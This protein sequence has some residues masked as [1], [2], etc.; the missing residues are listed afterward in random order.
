MSCNICLELGDL[1]R[2][3]S[4]VIEMHEECMRLWHS[5]IGYG[6][7]IQSGNLCCP[8]CKSPGKAQ[9]MSIFEDD[10]EITD[11]LKILN[12]NPDWTHILC[13]S[14][15]ILKKYMQESCVTHIDDT[16]RLVCSD[17]S[18]KT[19]KECPTCGILIEKAEG[20]LHMT[21]NCGT[22]FC[23]Q[24]LEIH[25]KDNIYKHINQKHKNILEDQL[26]YEDY[27][28][29]VRHTNLRL[30]EVPEEYWT[31]ELLLHA[32][33]KNGMTLQFINNQ[34][35]EI[36]LEA[37][38][39]TSRAFKYV[40]NK[41]KIICLEAVKKNGLLLDFVENQDK[42]I[43]LEAVRK[44]G[45]TLQFINNQTEE[46][47]LEAVKET[48]R[49]FKYVKHKTKIICLEA[50]KKNGL[51]LDFVENQDEEI[52]L[53]AIRKNP[54]ALIY[55]KD[56]TKK[57]CLE[58]VRKNGNTLK[59]VEKQDEEI[60]LEAVKETSYAFQYV[61]KEFKDQIKKLLK[62]HE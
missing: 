33:R 60:C 31:K 56:K 57:I 48:S 17:C 20:C 6:K 45:M 40:K 41:T 55:V 32:V 15:K 5:N 11:I 14:C 49:A 39:E 50:V 54:F 12:D 58:A 18:P 27:I 53:D 51:L 35:E 2:P 62:I 9:Y 38:K 47:C 19:Y 7:V 26:R 59:C 1:I 13:P 28:Y 10:K 8:Y 43:C 30:D 25:D 46:I 44:N 29:R 22:H 52:C 34:T 23:W 3:C 61:D 16:Y 42:E 4:C 36:C 37:V 21:C 24:C